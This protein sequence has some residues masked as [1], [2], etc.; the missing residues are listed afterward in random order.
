MLYE[1]KRKW[2][3]TDDLDMHATVWDFEN[4]ARG[5]HDQD[6]VWEREKIIEI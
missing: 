4:V 5:G 3:R 1:K 2:V 6:R